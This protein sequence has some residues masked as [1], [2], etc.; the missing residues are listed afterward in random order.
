MKW[1][2]GGVV[3]SDAEREVS[4]AEGEEWRHHYLHL[5]NYICYMYMKVG[6]YYHLWGVDNAPLQ[7]PETNTN[8]GTSHEK[9]PF[10]LLLS[11][12]KQIPI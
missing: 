5:P 4:S 2:T 8:P 12:F 6:A 11:D 10:K 9:P 7:E 1:K 3:V